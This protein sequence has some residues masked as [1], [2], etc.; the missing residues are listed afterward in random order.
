MT[1][2]TFNHTAPLRARV[3]PAIDP[4]VLGLGAGVYWR[5]GVLHG[6][7]RIREIAAGA[8]EAAVVRTAASQ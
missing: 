2:Y 3:H 8:G 5:P 6:I 1:A 7:H 4:R